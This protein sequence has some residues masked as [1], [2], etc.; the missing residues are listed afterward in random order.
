[1]LDFRRERLQDDLRGLVKGEVLCDTVCTQLFAT[2][3]SIYEIPPLGVVNPKNTADVVAVIHYA[4]EH[5]IPISP[6]GAGSGTSGGALGEGIVLNTSRFMR[7]IL[8]MQNGILKVQAG[9]QC[10]WLNE[11]MNP[12]GPCWVPVRKST[13]RQPSVAC[14]PSM[15]TAVAGSPLDGLPTGC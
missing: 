11:I 5:G 12:H 2:D 4:R 1:M 9:V 14:C 15:A 7:R 3:A 13:L 10:S 6:R 8:T